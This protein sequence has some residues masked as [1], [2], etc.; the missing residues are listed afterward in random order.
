MS[1]LGWG[2]H[3][4]SPHWPRGKERHFLNFS[5][6]LPPSLRLQ[7]LPS[8]PTPAHDNLTPQICCLGNRGAPGPAPWLKGRGANPALSC[9]QLPCACRNS[10]GASPQFLTVTPGRHFD[11][12]EGQ[13]LLTPRG[14]RAGKGGGPEQGPLWSY[15]QLPSPATHAGMITALI[16]SPTHIQELSEGLWGL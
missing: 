7:S 11:G 5:V 4:V 2:R 6:I 9:A 14:R 13:G 8:S 16:F 15:A 12:E 1:G 3:W 10:W